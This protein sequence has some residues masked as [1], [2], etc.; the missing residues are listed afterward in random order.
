MNA[1]EKAGGD[2]N[3]TRIYLS[4]GRQLEESLKRIRAKGNQ[5]EAAKVARGF[6]ALPHPSGR[7][8]A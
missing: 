4:L 8:P 3:L 7:P 6:T 1:L 5:E 2:A